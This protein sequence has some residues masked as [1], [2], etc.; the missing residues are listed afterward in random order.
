[1]GEDIC[2]HFDDAARLRAE[3]RPTNLVITGGEPLIWS[4]FLTDLLWGTEMNALFETVE[5]ETN[6]TMIPLGRAINDLAK[7]HYNVSPKLTNS[8]NLD[9][10]TVYPAVI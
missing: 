1:M 8:G 10:A 3:G 7:V 5:I 2:R 4:T 6:G 9:R